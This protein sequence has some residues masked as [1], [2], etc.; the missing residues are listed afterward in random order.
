MARSVLVIGESGAGKTTSCRTLD[1]QS[2]FYI[3]CDKKGLAWRGWKKMYNQ[4]SKNYYATSDA[5]TIFN[6]LQK[7]NK[8]R[9]SKI[10][11]VVIDT[12]NAI[13]LEDEFKR[14]KEKGYDKWQDLAASIY[15][16]IDY[17]NTMRE[18]LTIICI[19]HAQTERDESGFSF[20]R[21]KTSGKKLEK[22]VV[23]SKFTTVLLAKPLEGEYIFETKANQSTAKT[24]MDCFTSPTIPNDMAAVIKALD[25]YEKGE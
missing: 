13:M 8:N 9:E 21:M 6:F 18:D 3:D 22:I 5:N 7:L 25:D 16:L 11:T 12:L 17:I 19:A 1:P 15:Y 20:T 10:K 4:E 23:E 14:M 24:P 2:T